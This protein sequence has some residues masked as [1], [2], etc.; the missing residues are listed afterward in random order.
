MT[1]NPNQLHQNQFARHLSRNIFIGL[2]IISLSLFMGMW[3]Y[4]HFIY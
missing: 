4:H 3:G 2:L 1:Q